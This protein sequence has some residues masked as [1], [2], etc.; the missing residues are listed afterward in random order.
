[1]KLLVLDLLCLNN[2]ERQIHYLEKVFARYPELNVQ[3]RAVE[4]HKDGLRKEDILWADKIVTSGSIKS[5]YHELEWGDDLR[6]G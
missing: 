6:R 3:M 4:V 2:E 1:M 5:A